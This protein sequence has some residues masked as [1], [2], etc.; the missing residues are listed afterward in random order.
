MRR[1]VAAAYFVAAILKTAITPVWRGLIPFTLFWLMLQGALLL[2]VCRH[3]SGCAAAN[4]YELD[5]SLPK[6]S[7][8][9]G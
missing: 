7:A 5:R 2:G 3:R 6:S 1:L 9:P 4:R 8:T